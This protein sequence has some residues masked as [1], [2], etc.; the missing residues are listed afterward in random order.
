MPIVRNHLP[1]AE[2]ICA[3]SKGFVNMIQLLGLQFPT[4]SGALSR[5]GW[6]TMYLDA[7]HGGCQRRAVHKAYGNGAP[8]H[9]R[10]SDIRAIDV[11]GC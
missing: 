6:Y 5:S 4:V 11:P 2:Q 9:D 8:A 7:K 10:A 3:A 1:H